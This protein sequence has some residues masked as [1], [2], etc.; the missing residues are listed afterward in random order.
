MLRRLRP[1]EKNHRCPSYIRLGRPT[2]TSFA[3]GR[4]LACTV[5][6]IPTALSRLKIL[7]NDMLNFVASITAVTQA[8]ST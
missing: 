7:S 1:R 4:Y 8:E 6:A 3:L 2:E 5:V